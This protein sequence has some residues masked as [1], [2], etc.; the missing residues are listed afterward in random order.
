MDTFKFISMI[1]DQL[2]NIINDNLEYYGDIKFLV[3][4][5]RA[6]LKDKNE[7]ERNCCYIVVKFLSASIYYNQTAIP[8]TLNCVCEYNS[9]EKIR[10]LLYEFAKRY[11]LYWNEDKTLEQV[12]ETP[13]VDSEFEEVYEG[14]DSLISMAGALLIL[15]NGNLCTIQYFPM[16]IIPSKEIYYK[17][18]EENLTDIFNPTIDFET[19][20]KYLKANKY[21]VDVSKENSYYFQKSK[22][23]NLWELFEKETQEKQSSGNYT[24]ISDLYECGVN[25]NIID[26]YYEEEPLDKIEFKISRGYAD[27]NYLSFNTHASISLDSQPFFSNNNFT[28]SKGKFGSFSMNLTTYLFDNEFLNKCLS[29]YLGITETEKSGIDTNFNF[30]IKFNNGIEKDKILKLAD[31]A[32]SQTEGEIPTVSLTFSE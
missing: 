29:I 25:L 28:S 15:D 22:D 7:D 2:S 17:R 30:K 10:T 11:N 26:S 13:N 23:N 21:S 4:E 18:G 9:L 5:E 1:S 20:Y 32:L 31:L 8:I 27:I 12:W 16:S 19:F 14:F 6:F 3:Q 24:I